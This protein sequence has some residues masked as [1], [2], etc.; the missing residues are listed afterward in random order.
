M[1][2][3]LCLGTVQLGLDYGMNNKRGK[4]SREESLAILD[5]AYEGGIEVFDTAYAYGD[6]ED[7]LG[8]WLEGRGLNNKISVISKL[9]PHTTEVEEEVKKSL[10]RL[11]RDY[12]DGYLLHTPEY[13]YND[14]VWSALKSVKKKGL[15]KNIGVSIYEEKDAMYA[16]QERKVDYVQIPYSVFDQR[17]HKTDFFE[18][19]RKNG[20]KVFAR[21]AFLQGLVFMDEG[22]I[23]DYLSDAKEYLREFNNI[24]KKHGFTRAEAAL[25]FS[26]KNPAI[27]YVVFGVDNIE[28]LEE[29]LRI[30]RDSKNFD[31]CA[32]ELR[33]KFTDIKKSII[34]PSLWKSRQ[35][36]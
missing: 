6:A 9:K 2:N 31:A 22:A 27:D 21:S 24:I 13:I 28:Q 8:E 1:A 29:N 19:A 26:H 5:R 34:F 3:K 18:T 33:D 30:I 32:K 25:L 17:L 23:P 7:I 16:V 12:L 11:K 4:P 10:A 14:A 15:V 35:K 36:K 20:V